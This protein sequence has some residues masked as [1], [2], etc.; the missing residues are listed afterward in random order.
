MKIREKS[1]F[2]TNQIVPD[3]RHMPLLERLSKCMGFLSK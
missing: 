1:D 3:D 2:D